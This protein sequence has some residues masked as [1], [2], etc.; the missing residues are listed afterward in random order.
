MA[1]RS[2]IAALKK[3]NG[4]PFSL[5]CPHYTIP[6][7]RHVFSNGK[8]TQSWDGNPF[9][10]EEVIVLSL[11]RH[12][13]EPLLGYEEETC[14]CSISV[15]VLEAMR[16][17][18]F[19][20][21]LDNAPW[22][23]GILMLPPQ[24]ILRSYTL[25]D[26][27]EEVGSIN[28]NSRTRSKSSNRKRT[29]SSVMTRLHSSSSSASASAQ[30]DVLLDDETELVEMRTQWMFEDSTKNNINFGK[31]KEPVYIRYVDTF[32]AQ[33]NQIRYND[34]YSH[35]MPLY[36]YTSPD[37]IPLILKTGLR[38]STQGQGDGG[39]YFSTK[40]PVSYGKRFL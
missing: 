10:N 5:R 1:R 35:L 17:S 38:M 29:K 2:G 28:S 9:P 11:P 8:S 7:E 21:V 31:I 37:I 39:V 36:H 3:F 27:S 22:L 15:Q 24:C 20:T 25:I 19:A 30:G 40:G 6:I 34:A 32:L 4:I 14:L 26:N 13:L 12:L 18:T 23:E 33:M 16:S